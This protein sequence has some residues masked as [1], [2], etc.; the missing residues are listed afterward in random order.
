M[1]LFTR[2]SNNPL[3]SLN[4]GLVT[5][6]RKFLNSEYV[7]IPIFIKDYMGD[8]DLDFT[9]EFNYKY[10]KINDDLTIDFN[11]SI[12]ISLYSIFDIIENTKPKYTEIPSFIKFNKIIGDFWIHNNKIKSLKGCPEFVE[13][14]FDCSNNNLTSLEGC[15]KVV[16][17]KFI[18]YNNKSEF[19]ENYVKSL[20]KVKGRII[21][22]YRFILDEI[23]SGKLETTNKSE[24][25]GS[26]L[27]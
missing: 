2:T 7:Y 4:V 1:S 26:N 20:C 19:T 21:T 25:I 12:S 15:P 18:C 5:E 13:G 22:K 16:N 6:I 27:F 10:Y 24:I 3:I 17:G 14:D 9:N 11:N 8:E 23:I